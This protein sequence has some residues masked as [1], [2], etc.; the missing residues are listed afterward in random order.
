[1]KTCFSITGSEESLDNDSS[2]SVDDSVEGNQVG[3]TMSDIV[4]QKL[5]PPRDLRRPL[6]E[7][8]HYFRSMKKRSDHLKAAC[9]KNKMAA[10][11]VNAYY[12]YVLKVGIDIR[13]RS[14][15]KL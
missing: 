7:R 14:T 8:N 3:L 12:L 13:D 2:K 15:Y 6:E 10:S 11:S 4:S 5:V 9:K 1:M